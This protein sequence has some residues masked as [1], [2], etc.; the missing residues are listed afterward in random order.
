M[1][2]RNYLEGLGATVGM[3]FERLSDRGDVEADL[4][5]GNCGVYK[6][7]QPYI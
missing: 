1:I 5:E 3:M 4:K 7:Y 2:V 6:E